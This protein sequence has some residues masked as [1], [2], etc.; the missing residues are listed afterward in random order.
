RKG[1]FR[2]AGRSEATEQ[3]S[4]W[5]WIIMKSASGSFRLQS[6]MKPY[7]KTFIPIIAYSF[8]LVFKCIM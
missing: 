7:R 6:P 8:A 1:G 4:C 5:S 3:S 2:L